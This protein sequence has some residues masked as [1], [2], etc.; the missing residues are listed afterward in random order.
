VGYNIILFIAGIQGIPDDF[1]EA[2]QIDGAGPVKRFFMITM[3]LLARTLAFVVA[4]TFIS[5]FQAF[6]QFSIMTNDGG[7]AGRAG[8]VLSTYIYNTGFKNKDMGYAS[9]VSLAL[10]AL[11]MIVTVAQRRI[12]RVDWGY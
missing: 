12:N 5:Q 11:I 2:A 6:A 10:F 8:Y 7:G 4:M 9:T 1:Y 3:P